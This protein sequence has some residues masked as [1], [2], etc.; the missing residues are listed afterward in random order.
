MLQISVNKNYVVTQVD[1]EG[2]NILTLVLRRGEVPYSLPDWDP[3]IWPAPCRPSDELDDH[4]LPQYCDRWLPMG[5]NRKNQ[6]QTLTI[7][8]GNEG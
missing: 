6:P 7:G 4:M 8:I 5:V 2:K 3:L 1:I